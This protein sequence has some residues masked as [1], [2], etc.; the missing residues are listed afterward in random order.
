[1]KADVL[2][3][4]AHPDDAELSCGGTI[5]SLTASGKK[6]VIVDLTQGEMGTRGTLETRKVEAALSAGIL[7]LADRVQLYLADT[8][9]SNDR[10]TQTS[11]IQAIRRFQ[12]EIVLCNAIDDRHPDH[13]R[14]AKLESDA[15]FYSGLSKIETTWEGEL[16]S[17]WRPGLVFHY[18]QDRWL[19]PDLVID[20]SQHWETKL[21]AIKAF[22]T[23]FFDPN[24]DEPETY[25]STPVFWQFLEARAREAGHLIGVSHGEGFISQRP[26]GTTDLFGLI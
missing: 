11:L 12:P 20:I 15:C 24:S 21:S 17:P 4:A 5:A 7:N 10:T 1:M 19:K 16:Q 25:I 3:F 6:V 8:N 9:F 18:V 13:G 14:A 23:Q 26:I 2:V 22:K